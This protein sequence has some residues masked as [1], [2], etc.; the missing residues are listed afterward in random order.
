VPLPVAS[1]LL[2]LALVPVAFALSGCGERSEPLGAL[3]QSYPVTVRG[4][5]DRATTLDV[6]PGRVVALDA[7]SAE[8]ITA[9]D[10][11]Q[12]LVGGP[13][14]SRTA[15]APASV[16]SRT[17]QV[18]VGAVVRLKPDLIVS[19][20]AVD[21]LDAALAQRR[22]GAALY[23]QPDSSVADVLRGTIELGFL[24]GEPVR[25]RQLAARLQTQVSDVEAKVAGEPTV[26]VFVD[27]GFFITIPERSL[28]GDL[29]RRAHGESV[30]GE[31]PGPDPFPPSRL[32]ELDPDVYIATSESRVT[33]AQL[34]ADPRTA[35]LTPVRE[36]RFA[37]L[38]SD[39]VVR[40]GPRLGQAFARVAKALHPDAF[41]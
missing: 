33:L 34:R 16:V 6:R 27:T 31:A 3:P 30:A 11:G 23:V 19:T 28:L 8:L 41:R 13:A 9:L 1:R 15:E 10:G 18:D 14:G 39:L 22:S 35:R 40:P 26:T 37:V 7:G 36:K 2:L 4:G 20:S 12:R 5:G 32:R 17:G 29:L 21:Q 24:L 38:P 25:A